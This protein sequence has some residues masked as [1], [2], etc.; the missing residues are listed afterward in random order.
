MKL[1]ILGLAAT[2]VVLFA[3]GLATLV[4]PSSA[5]TTGSIVPPTGAPCPTGDIC[6]P[7]G[8]SATVSTDTQQFSWYSVGELATGAVSAV[9][10]VMAA[11]KK[12]A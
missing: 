5:H 1:L 10:A 4:I 9:A 7:A 8:T 11:R 12:G 6:A 3:I 2:A